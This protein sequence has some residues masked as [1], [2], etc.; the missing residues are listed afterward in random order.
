MLGG[1]AA[2]MRTIMVIDH[3]PP[4]EEAEKVCYKVYNNLSFLKDFIKNENKI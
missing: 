4:S 2:G 3:N 1:H